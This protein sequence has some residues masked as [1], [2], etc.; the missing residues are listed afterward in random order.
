MKTLKKKSGLVRQ[1]LQIF[2]SLINFIRCRILYLH[3]DSKLRIIHKD[4]KAS[5]VLLDNK[6]NPKISY[7]FEIIL[8]T[9]FF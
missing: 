8:F 4:L 7:L 2:C 9:L 5:N 6:M 1:N 3:H